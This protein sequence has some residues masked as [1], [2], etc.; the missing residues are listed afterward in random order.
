MIN[1]T[2]EDYDGDESKLRAAVHYVSWYLPRTYGTAPKPAG[3]TDAS[4][5]PLA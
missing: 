3:W 4:F 2:L 5:V 1:L